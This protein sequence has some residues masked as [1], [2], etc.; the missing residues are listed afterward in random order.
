MSQGEDEYGFVGENLENKNLA[1]V[2][3]LVVKSKA[4]YCLF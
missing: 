4:S 1:V 3:V 2:V